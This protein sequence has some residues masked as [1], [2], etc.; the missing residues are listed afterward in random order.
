[1]T[2][3]VAL[4]H[5]VDGSGPSLVALHGMP[6]DR[7]FWDRVPLHEHPAR[8]AGTCAGTASPRASGP[9]TR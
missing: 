4:A 8:F 3:T 6:E 9:A 5:V 7:R 2:E 1:M